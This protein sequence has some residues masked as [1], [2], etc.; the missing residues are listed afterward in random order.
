MSS[1][2]GE[3]IKVSIFG[4]SHSAGIGVV[5]DG[6]PANYKIDFDKVL[7][8]MAR[9]APGQDKTSTKRKEADFPKIMSGL[10]NDTTEGSP[11]CAVI[12]NTNTKSADYNSVLSCP[13]PGH[14][15]YCAFI[16]YQN[17]NDIRG[18]G[19]FSGRLTAP[20]VFA[21]AVARQILEQKGIF[22]AAHAQQIYNVCDEKFDPI[23]VDKKLLERLGNEFFPV[24]NQETKAKM[25][26]AV[27]QK[28]LENDSVGGIIECAVVG[29]PC[30]LGEP[31][32]GGVENR[33]SSALF[34]IPAVKAV[35]FGLGFDVV[36]Q[37]GSTNN[38]E[39]YYDEQKNVKTYTNNC[40]GIL[41]GITNSMPLIFRLAIKPT[42]SISKEQRTVDLTEKVNTTLS[43]HGRH[44]PCIVPRAV[45]VIE[46]ITALTVLDMLN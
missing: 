42:P 1:I 5:I 43:I 31:M 26:E 36:N 44:D 2:L 40:G 38:D 32:F 13:R 15:D 7:S 9:R 46:A 45:P 41:G 28:R 22:L 10:I 17:A 25:Y 8:Q 11:L 18:G 14:S 4:E 24:I 29:L 35:E 30:G 34:G 37:T 39:F 27:E 20:I 19:H 3:K 16:K 33:L 6:L 21:G 12:E 23:N